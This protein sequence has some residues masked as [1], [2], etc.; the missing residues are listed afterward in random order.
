MEKKK[1]KKKDWFNLGKVQISFWLTW[2][3]MREKGA[4]YIASR[5][6]RGQIIV[7]PSH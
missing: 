5:E 3:L 1:K 7:C 2:S 6:L 4:Q